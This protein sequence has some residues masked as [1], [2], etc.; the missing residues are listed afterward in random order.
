M[1]EVFFPSG[2]FLIEATREA[3]EPGVCSLRPGRMVYTPSPI[4]LQDSEIIRDMQL[5][6]Q[7][8]W[9]IKE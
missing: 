9:N 6:W 1:I 2:W 3:N 7:M 5:V 4:W 8:P